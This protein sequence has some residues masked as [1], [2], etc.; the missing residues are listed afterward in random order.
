MRK[1]NKKIWQFG[2]IICLLI[3]NFYIP[4]PIANAQ[5][6]GDL[7]KELADFKAEYE[8]NKEE[9][10]LTEE[11]L[12]QAK[13]EINTIE[14]NIVAAQEEIVNLNNEIEQLNIEIKNK[15]EEIEDILVFFQVAS[16]EN[17]YLEYAFGA[18][19]FTDFIYRLAVSEQ[20]TSYNDQLVAEYQQ[21]I[22]D[23]K[24]KTEE[25][26]QKQIDLANERKTLEKKVQEISLRV[27]RLDDY[28]LSIEEQIKAQENE[29]KI[30]EEAGCKDTDD[31]NACIA[32]ATPYDTEFWLPLEIG[33][34]TGWAEPR[35]NPV[36]GIYEM[37]HGVDMSRSGA[38]STDYAVYPVA[39]GVVTNIINLT[40][41]SS[42]SYAR[43]CGGRK[44]FIQ[45]NINGKIYTSAYWHLRE[46]DVE[47]GQVV[48]K[49]TKIGVMG[50]NPATDY[51]DKDSY[52]NFCTTGAHL[53]L[54][55]SDRKVSAGDGYGGYRAGFIAPQYVI[56][57]PARYEYWYSRH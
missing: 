1:I 11:E 50:G 36:T 41:T 48:S 15:E 4:I 57:F 52:G 31:L 53:H 8:K 38:N 42:G 12:N 54:E 16:G 28:G 9:Q 44:V 22:E 35:Y 39:N 30:Y 27:D 49:M 19:D 2:F 51:W 43:N 46:I 37:H 21:N 25:L 10:Q 26:A 23:N 20:L 32:E 13:S 45:H 3:S 14:I 6:L 33:Q 47:I 29:I 18:K 7:K 5:T 40:V 34:V 17:A 55:L 24:K 56:D